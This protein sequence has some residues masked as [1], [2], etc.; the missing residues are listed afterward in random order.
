[1]KMGGEGGERPEKGLMNRGMPLA[2]S[3]NIARYSILCTFNVDK[4]REYGMRN[5]RE[6]YKAIVF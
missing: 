1:M 5:E 6:V 4:R 3:T 2:H